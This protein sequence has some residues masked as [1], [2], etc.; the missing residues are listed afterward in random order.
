M[1]EFWKKH[2][3]LST[4]N[5]GREASLTEC[6]GRR[7]K[8]QYSIVHLLEEISQLIPAEQIF[9]FSLLSNSELKGQ[10]HLLSG[11]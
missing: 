10:G 3:Q 9:F 6:C 1:L 11:S 8:L 2:F 5:R 4:R 7:G